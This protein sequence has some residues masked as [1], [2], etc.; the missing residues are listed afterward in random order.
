M[1][2]RFKAVAA[3]LLA[4]VSLH[5]IAAAETVLRLDEVPVGELDPAKAS[6]YADSIL[7]FNLYD[8]LVIPKAG[9]PGFDAFLSTGWETDGRTYTFKLRN[10]V[11]F[12]SGNPLTADDV[13]FSFQ[14]MQ[15]LG[16]GLSYLFTAVE[17]AEA[18]DASTV[19]FTLKEAYAPFI[20]ALTRLPIIDKKLVTENL[21]DGDGEMKDWGQAYLTSH[22][23]GT[24]AYKVVSHNPQ[25]ET[26]MAKN[27]GYFL[28]VPPKAPDTVRF[29]YGLEAATV[30]TLISQ[31]EHDI[32]SSWLPPEVLK[33]LA[34]EGAQLL[35]E[36]GT[37]GFY[38]KMNTTKAPFDDV[39][40]RLAVSY[41]FDYESGVKMVGVTDTV[42]QGS[43]STGAIPVGMLGALPADQVFKRDLDKAKEHLAKC[44]Y[45]PED[46]K[47][48][49]S[50]IGEVPIEE[51]F[52]LLMQANFSEIGIK[53]E[54]KKLPW[55]LFV[56]QISKP[57]NTPS[58]SQVFVN[59][60]SADPDTLLYGM[61]HS[62]SA[63]TWMSPEYLNDKD[64]DA[65]LE[66]G[67]T[68]ADEA[69]RTKIYTDLNTRLREIAPTIFAQ[70]QTAVFAA[71]NRVSVPALSDLSKAYAL[72]GFGFNF[73]LME[74]K[75]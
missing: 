27:A 5:G 45:K 19:K 37:T 52:A 64:V 42:S 7:M 34:A 13:V 57:E 28:G 30:R 20:S 11:K 6:D 12:Q 51:R 71:S 67:R 75:E 50:W 58:I 18:V 26:V 62:S 53:A 21:A 56:E 36:K 24:G 63:G 61:Y 40:C 15:A 17:K 59:T 10:D 8:T 33:S 35:E 43:P 32:S 70:D 47:V 14:R 46:M 68:T 44:K 23:A 69:E 55:A 38:I 60:M 41:A 1:R 39:E 72:A 73:R 3:A 54:V 66:K 16:Q 29:R 22:A 25:E 49:L 74:M 4:T 65:L 9:Q 2:L 48:E 31:G